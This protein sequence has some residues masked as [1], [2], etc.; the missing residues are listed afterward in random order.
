M[1]IKRRNHRP[2]RFFT[3]LI[4][5]KLKKPDVLT[6]HN[7]VNNMVRMDITFGIMFFKFYGWDGSSQHALDISFIHDGLSAAFGFGS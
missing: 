7:T 3:K 2:Y 6:W 1:S 5:G 4:N